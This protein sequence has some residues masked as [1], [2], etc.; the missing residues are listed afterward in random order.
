M[1]KN[2][3]FKLYA[4]LSDYLP[5]GAADNAIQLE[6]EEDASPR[7]ILDAHLVPEKLA[8]LVLINGVYVNSSDRD[9]PLDDG[10]TLA[11]WPPVAGG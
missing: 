1:K 10:D 11:V 4:G 9:R 2:I 3:R 7:S 6:V 5:H 8:H